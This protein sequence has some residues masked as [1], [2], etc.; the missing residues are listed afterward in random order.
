MNVC[1]KCK[2][3]APPPPELAPLCEEMRRLFPK[4][5]YCKLLNAVK[6]YKPNTKAQVFDCELFEPME[7]A[8]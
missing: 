7:S 2:H 4:V 5:F 8:Q 1:E 3:N 6:C